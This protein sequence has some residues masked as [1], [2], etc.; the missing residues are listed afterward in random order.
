MQLHRSPNPEPVDEGD[1]DERAYTIPHRRR[2]TSAAGSSAPFTPGSRAAARRHRGLRDLDMARKR[3]CASDDDD[4]PFGPGTKWV[5]AYHRMGN[6]NYLSGVSM[7][8]SSVPLPTKPSWEPVVQRAAWKIQE[9]PHLEEAAL[10]SLQRQGCSD[11]VKH[12]FSE[13][14]CE[15]PKRRLE[16]LRQIQRWKRDR[17][18]VEAVATK[19]PKELAIQI[20]QYVVLASHPHTIFQDES[21]LPRTARE[22]I[23]DSIESEA[24]IQDLIPYVGESILEQ[25]IFDVE[26]D[27]RRIDGQRVAVLP[28]DVSRLPTPFRKLRITLDFEIPIGRQKY[29]AI[30]YIATAG[31]PSLLEQLSGLREL[32]FFLRIELTRPPWDHQGSA[33]DVGCRKGFS[34]TSTFRKAL[35]ELVDAVR[36]VKPSLRVHVELQYIYEGTWRGAFEAPPKTYNVALESS[37]EE[38]IRAADFKWQNCRF[39]LG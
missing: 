24:I 21:T 12:Y 3:P 26:M 15:V 18:L 11:P 28:P 9:N 22:V 7:P 14:E 8:S 19:L 16:C 34:S 2:S 27:F 36:S 35:E 33:L 5:R 23:G 4:D 29:P 25:S 6:H 39:S 1:V 13:H 38:T 10:K 37:A 31:V 30:L 32:H 17:C 20:Y